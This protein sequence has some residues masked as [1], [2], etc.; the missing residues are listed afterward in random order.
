MDMLI[1]GAGGHGKVVADVVACEGRHRVV[2]FLDSDTALHGTNVAG[3][4]V[5][6]GVNQLLKL[7]QKIRG[8]VIAIGDNAVR[9]R[10]SQEMIDIGMELITCVHPRA[11][12][13]SSAVL[14]RGVVVCAMAVVG[15]DTTVGDACVINTSA[16]VDHECVIGDAVHICPG[17][18]LAG[19]VRVGDRAF[20]GMG[21]KIIQCVS[22]GAA[23]IIGAGAVVTVDLPERVTAVGI[24]ARVIK[25]N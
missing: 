4:P 2:G 16:V 10:Y 12:V 11:S 1:I 18:V 9:Q 13:A 20:I 22:V 24:P 15:V 21:A 7:K 17:A 8:V 23:A 19:R 6:G 5:L 3:V 14:G 25:R